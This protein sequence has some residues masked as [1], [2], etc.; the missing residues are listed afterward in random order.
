MRKTRQLL[1]RAFHF[2]FR[3]TT[4]KTEFRQ[5]RS[6]CSCNHRFVVRLLLFGLDKNQQS[7]SMQLA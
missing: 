4:P 6:N 5:L 3:V 2:F 1:Q 7:S